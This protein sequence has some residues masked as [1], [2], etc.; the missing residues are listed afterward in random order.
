MQA[1]ATPAALDAHEKRSHELCKTAGLFKTWASISEKEVHAR[2]LYNAIRALQL[3]VFQSSFVSIA[4]SWAT[5]FG[6]TAHRPVSERKLRY[7][8][9][10]Q[11]RPVYDTNA[12]V[13]NPHHVTNPQD[14]PG[15][16]QLRYFSLGCESKTGLCELGHQHQLVSD[17][18]SICFPL[19]VPPMSKTSMLELTCRGHSQPLTSH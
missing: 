18:P 6:N 3:N 17:G 8:D 2:H 4:Q 12:T 7:T 1:I 5:G 19:E 15:F 14:I 11:P 9:S 10:A 16:F 13:T